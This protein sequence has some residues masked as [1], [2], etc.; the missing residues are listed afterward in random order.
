MIKKAYKFLENFIALFNK[1]RLAVSSAGLSY[2]MTMT[3]F[4]LIMCLYSMLGYNQE[5]ALRIIRF[6]D[7]FL[8]RDTIKL[9][10]DF[11]RYIGE[12]NSEAMLIAG[13]VVLF[14]SASAAVRSLNSTIGELQGGRRFMGLKHYL[15]SLVFS[16]IL[17]AS[18]YFGMIVMLTGR[19]FIKKVNEF[20]PFIDISG[21]W[22]WM[23]FLVLAGLDFVLVWAVY[24]MPKR[25]VD[26][27]RTF[28]G[29]ILTTVALVVVSLVFSSFIS[30]SAKYPLV[31]GSLA[32][33][34]LLMLWIYSCGIV[35][36]GGAAFNIVLYRFK[37]ENGSL[38]EGNK[39]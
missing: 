27:Y 36:Y 24:E 37:Q 7:D 35:I 12:N 25:S 4:P 15:F 34:V 22:N 31:Y 1:N 2:Y 9:L 3:F 14:T 13:I 38:K 6:L 39:E 11:L 5:Q 23:R 20:L 32:S 21:T 30:H 29:A 10:E 18:A 26:K 8:D 28:P 33:L 17:L 16:F 19:A